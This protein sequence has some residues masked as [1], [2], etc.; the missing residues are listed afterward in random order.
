M[1]YFCHMNVNT[2][3][4]QIKRE[5]GPICRSMLIWFHG[6]NKKILKREHFIFVLLQSI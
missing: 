1:D 4:C 3:E 2:E 6:N 5:S